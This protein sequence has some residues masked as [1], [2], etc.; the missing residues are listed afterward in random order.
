MADTRRA[1]DYF[2]RF[3]VIGAILFAVDYGVRAWFVTAPEDDRVITIT[4]AQ[5]QA[6]IKSW[7][8]EHGSAPSPEERTRLIDDLVREEV[9]YREAKRRGLDRDD[10][11]IRRR[12]IQKME[13]LALDLAEVETPTEAELEQWL[14]AHSDAY[15]RPARWTLTQVL[16]S[17][18]ERG[19]HAEADAEAALRALP[20]PREGVAPSAG[21]PSP[22]PFWLPGATAREL[23][24]MFGDAFARSLEDA[25][26]KRWFGP[27]P[28]AFGVHLVWIHE[29]IPGRVPTLEEVRSRVSRDLLDARAKAAQKAQFQALLEHYR[30]VLPE[31]DGVAERPE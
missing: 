15:R 16:F 13:F 14:A 1:P 5:I 31:D 24:G 29:K 9:L 12:L 4:D 11:I 27:V 21:D 2:W 22:L 3:L 20:S 23:D 30:I 6:L 26:L 17:R 7:E 18:D 19:E 10:L 28:S 25:P 8:D